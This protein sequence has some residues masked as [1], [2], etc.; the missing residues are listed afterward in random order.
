MRIK[1]MSRQIARRLPG[2]NSLTSPYYIIEMIPTSS[3]AEV[4]PLQQNQLKI[5]TFFSALSQLSFAAPIA[6]LAE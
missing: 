1:I 2:L 3:H 4:P 6:S 5:S